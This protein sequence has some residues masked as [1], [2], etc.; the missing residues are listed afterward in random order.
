[1]EEHHYKRNG[2]FEGQIRKRSKFMKIKPFLVAGAIILTLLM[3]ACAKSNNSS[4]TGQPAVPPEKVVDGFYTSYLQAWP[5][6]PFNEISQLSPEFSKSLDKKQQEGMFI[7]P[8]ICAQDY[9]E[10]MEIQSSQ[11]DG[12]T[13]RVTVKSSFGNTIELTLKV[14]SG[15]WKIDNAVCK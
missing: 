3:S 5:P 12:D 7:V 11:V 9:P 2:H 13:A 8:F 6:T 1:M 14:I 15:E 4:S 10:K